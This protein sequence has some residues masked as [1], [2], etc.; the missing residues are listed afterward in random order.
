MQRTGGAK[1]VEDGMIGLTNRNSHAG[2]RA[3]GYAPTPGLPGQ[4]VIVPAEAVIIEEIFTRLPM[5][6][7]RARSS[8]NSTA[9]A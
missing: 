7:P 9:E 1:K 6:K 2:G 3:Y 5:A 4:P 8:P